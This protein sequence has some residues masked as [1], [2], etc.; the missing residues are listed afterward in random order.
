[1][2]QA[3]YCAFIQ[4]FPISW[5]QFDAEFKGHL[6]N[7]LSLWL[8]GARPMQGG[9]QRWDYRA[10]DPPKELMLITTEKEKET[11]HERSA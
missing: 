7:T 2:A 6:C 11:A 1:M 10:L 5:R 8:V 4:C 9:W 3:V